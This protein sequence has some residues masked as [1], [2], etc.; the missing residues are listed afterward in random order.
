MR[1]KNY[2]SLIFLFSILM[3][4]VNKCAAQ[5]FTKHEIKAA[6]VYNFIRF[7]TWPTE[8]KSLSIGIIGSN[9]FTETLKYTLTS[10]KI[11]FLPLKIQ[12]ITDSQDCSSFD[13]VYIANDTKIDYVKILNQI[14]GKSILS[15]AEIDGFCSK[16]G[17]INFI[18]GDNGNYFFEI[19]QQIATEE[20]IE[21]SSKLLRLAIKIK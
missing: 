16:N 9:K 11:G 2:I 17:I 21:I 10:Q 12:Q 4:N 1:F 3:L 15:I 14:K 8:K 19:N 5:K 20:K 7:V 18:E 6:Y 13:V